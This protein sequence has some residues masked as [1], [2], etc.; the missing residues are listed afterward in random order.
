MTARMVLAAYK[1][2][3]V[4]LLLLMT[5]AACGSAG[6]ATVTPSPVAA[7]PSVSPS[8]ANPPSAS[9]AYGVLVEPPQGNY[10]VSLVGTDGRVAARATT[11]GMPQPLCGGQAAGNV[12]LPVSTSDSRLYFLDGQGVVEFLTPDG[13]TGQASTVPAGTAS[14]RSMFAVSPDDRRIAV[15]VA[16]FNATGASTRLYV[17]DLGGGNHVEIFSE[18]GSYTI[19]P[20]GWHTTQ[21]L[22][23][24]KVRSCAGGI[25]P[26]CCGPLELHVVDPAT[27][28]RRFTLGGPDC[29]VAGAA[30]PTGVVCEV[31]PGFTEMRAINWTGGV[32]FTYKYVQGAAP[33]YLSPDGNAVA[34]ASAYQTDILVGGS[35]RLEAC[36][37]IDNSHLL[38]GGA[39][40]QVADLRK[41][42][43]IPVDAGGQCGGRIPGGL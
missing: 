18:A 17:E 35:R 7:T 26:F 14:R 25:S 12:P 32:I 4:P 41:T 27:A 21:N 22:V 43:L 13:K 9:G 8:A 37:W 38:A 24:A 39:R 1:R 6:V 5:T 40:G 42:D 3:G 34:V 19:W 2:T 29:V 23:V 31:T 36:E 20:I 11:S 28:D 15:V 33:A 16:D 10:T 30:S